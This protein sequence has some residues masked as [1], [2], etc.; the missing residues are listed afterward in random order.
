MCRSKFNVQIEKLFTHWKIICRLKNYLQTKK[1]STLIYYWLIDL[2]ST[3]I[4]LLLSLREK[5][6]DTELF[7]L[8]IFLYSCIP[9][10]IWKSKNYLQIKEICVIKEV[11]HLQIEEL[12]ADQRSISYAARRTICRTNNYLLQIEDLQIEEV[13]DMLIEYLQIEELSADQTIKFQSTYSSSICRQFFKLQIVLWS[14]D[15]SLVYR[16]NVSLLCRSFFDLE[17]IIVLLVLQSAHNSLTLRSSNFFACWLKF[18][19]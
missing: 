10:I 6:P 12:S 1:L 8:R 3:L 11:F 9:R 5:C 4:G 18:N 2:L 15:T 17:I 13:F 14:A 16:F 7:L 19:L